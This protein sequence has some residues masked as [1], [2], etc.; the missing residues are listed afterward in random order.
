MNS[1]FSP[2]PKQEQEAQ[3]QSNSPPP[4]PS[5]DRVQ[6]YPI[7]YI[8][9][10]NQPF[11]SSIQQTLTDHQNSWFVYHPVMQNDPFFPYISNFQNFLPKPS[12]INPVI[13]IKIEDD[14][15]FK[16]SKVQ[17]QTS[18]PD[19]IQIQEK[20]RSKKQKVQNKFQ[21]DIDNIADLEIQP[22]NCSQSNCLKRYCACFHS[23][24][25]C[26]DECQCKDCKN[27]TDFYEERDEAINHVYK[28]CHRDKKVPVNELLSLQ[29][30]YGCKC[31]TTGC[32][33]KYCECFKRGQICGEQCSCEG[34][35]NIPSAQNQKEL[36]R[37]KTVLK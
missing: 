29:M 31:K 4:P 35:L 18:K 26:L 2:Q 33:K 36:K 28:K 7:F 17:Q 9:H 11:H 1:Q 8:K 3:Q 5:Q 27:C 10:D 15:E 20:Q 25:M 21:R 24:R 12:T 14:E 34:C 6:Y 32:Q 19:L 23:G 16:Q 22:C 30:S 13:P 37:Q